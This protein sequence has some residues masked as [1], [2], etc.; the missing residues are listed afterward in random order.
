MI[1]ND[2]DGT[3]INQDCGSTHIEALQAFVKEKGL[4]V[5]FAY[6][7]DADRCLAV[8]EHGNVVDGDLILYICGKY[9]KEIGQLKDDMIVTTIMSNIG[10]YKACDRIGLNYQKTKVGD[11]YVFE[12]MMENGYRLGGEQSGHIIFSKHAT[13][14]DGILTSL[15]IMEVLLEKKTTLAALASEVKIYPQLLQN[16]R[17]TDKKAVL[18]HP[19]VRAAIQKVEEALGTDGRILVRESG[20]EP[21]LRVMVEATT[22]ELCETYVSQVI[23]TMKSVM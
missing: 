6:D 15:K 16:L 10:L 4:D 12:N 8:D 11:K 17:V 9:M 1:H 7:G 23:D 3:N 21:V 22:Q 2:P 18:E 14:G 13:T 5:G 20:T 19:E